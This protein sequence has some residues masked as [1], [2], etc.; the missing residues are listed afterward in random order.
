MHNIGRLMGDLGAAL[1]LGVLISSLPAAADPVKIGGTGSALGIM[2][3][4]AEAYQASSPGTQIVL[5]PA[6]GSSGGIKAVAA[7]VLDIG[8]SARPLK[9]AERGWNLAEREIART[10]LVLASMRQHAGFTLNDL[11]RVYDGRLSSW[12]DGSPLR[13]IL[14]L[15]SDS[16]TALLRAISPELDRALTAA[17]ARPGMHVAIVD[18]DSADAIERIPGALGSTTLALILSEQRRIKALPLNGVA[19]SVK[20]L[21]RGQYPYFKPLYFVVSSRP[22]QQA[23]GF[24]A[25]VES[26]Q[27]MRILSDNGYLPLKSGGK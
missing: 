18:Q 16:E 19:P 8:L 13:P 17:H 7:G 15:E 24:A 23:R 11:A 25:F 26:G 5:V 21:E 12:P 27:G 1:L 6:L 10:P 22:S 4:L 3:I 2:K 20:A 9:P 14:R